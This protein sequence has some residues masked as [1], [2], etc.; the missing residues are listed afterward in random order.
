[1]HQAKGE[2]ILQTD[3][4][5]YLPET[6]ASEMSAHFGGEV[7]LVSGPVLLTHSRHWLQSL[8]CLE[9]IGLVVLGAGSLAGGKPNMANGAN[10]AFRRQAFHEVGG[11]QGIDSV[12]SGDDELLLQKFHAAYP[13]QLRFAKSDQ[14]IVQTPALDNWSALKSQRLR[15]VSK[16]RT[17][18]NRGVNFVQLLSYLGFWSFPLCLLYGFWQWWGPLVALGLLLLKSIIDLV[19]MRKAAAFFH[20]LPLLRWLGLLELVYIPYVLW[21]G[22]AGNLVSRY[23]WKGRSVR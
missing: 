17:Y 18:Q 19:L 16:A 6:W 7:Q 9:S 20:K 2:I 4:D 15:W 23:E 3:A 22:I 11:Y 12:A 1:M 14:A 8:Q 5:C 21:I 10:L 13:G